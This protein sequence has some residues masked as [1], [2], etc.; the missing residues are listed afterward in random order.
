MELS[1]TADV[2]DGNRHFEEIACLPNL[3]RGVSGDRLRVR[4]RQQIVRV[5]AIDTA[6]AEMIGEPR[7]VGSFDEAFEFREVVAVQS[8][9]GTEIHGDAVLD[10]AVLLENRV[11][12]IERPAAID[13]EIFAD[14][15]EPVDDGLLAE[16]VTV[17]RDSQADPDAV[18]REI[19]EPIG[20]HESAVSVKPSRTGGLNPDP[21][22]ETK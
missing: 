19:V 2:F 9:G 7:G 1:V 6:P 4:H 18:I 5:P 20:W 22:C 3:L 13:H 14:D 15:L 10:D 8:L 11:E 16:D 21:P 12:H 17:M